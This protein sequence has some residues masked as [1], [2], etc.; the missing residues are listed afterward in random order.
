RSGGTPWTSTGSPT[1][2]SA[3]NGR[4]TTSRP[5]WP[6][7]VSSARRGPPDI[8][9]QQ[10]GRHAGAGRPAAGEKQQRHGQAQPDRQRPAEREQRGQQAEHPE[11][12]APLRAELGTLYRRR[13]HRLGEGGGQ[14]QPAD[15]V[16]LAVP[17]Q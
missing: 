9:R 3:K 8:P 5:S 15:R 12:P 1:A 13:R 14:E 11:T 4:P 7:S 2:R 16:A 17:G 10:P 6:S